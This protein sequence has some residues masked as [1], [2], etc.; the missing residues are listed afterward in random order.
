MCP[1]Q[2]N[3]CGNLRKKNKKT[4]INFGSSPQQLAGTNR[5]HVKGRGKASRT[6]LR[7]KCG[8]VCMFFVYVTMFCR[9]GTTGN[10]NPSADT[11]KL[12][13][14]RFSIKLSSNIVN[15]VASRCCVGTLSK[16]ISPRALCAFLSWARQSKSLFEFVLLI[17]AYGSLWSFCRVASVTLRCLSIERDGIS[18][19]AARLLVCRSVLQSKS[20]LYSSTGCCR[21]TAARFNDV[22]LLL[23]GCAFPCFCLTTRLNP[24][25]RA[26]LFS[27]G[28]IHRPRQS[29]VRIVWHSR[30]KKTH[31]KWSFSRYNRHWLLPPKTEIRCV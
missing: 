31:R 8:C 7:W 21:T 13:V 19:C 9:Y 3:G 14:N 10:F 26:K 12:A 25:G 30:S 11:T 16:R 22:R 29:A 17:R 5:D 6:P 20:S 4:P 15:I 27:W 2:W 23:G 18:V 1:E 24:V 28:I